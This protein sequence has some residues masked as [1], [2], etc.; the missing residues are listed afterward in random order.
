MNPRDVLISA[1]QATRDADAVIEDA[2]R[3]ITR[4]REKFECPHCGHWQSR[5]KD[6]R[7]GTIASTYWRRRECDGCGKRFTT[8]ETIIGNYDAA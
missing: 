4:R 3:A 8:Q 2:D 7:P 1:S 5:V 6:A